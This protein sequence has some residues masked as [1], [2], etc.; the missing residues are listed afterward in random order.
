MFMMEDYPMNRPFYIG[1]NAHLFLWFSQV[2][3][4]HYPSHRDHF[5]LD[6]TFSYTFRTT[7]NAQTFFLQS[8][9]KYLFNKDLGPTGGIR[10]VLTAYTARRPNLWSPKC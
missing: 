9:L 3:G 4:Y 8:A 6:F 10:T 7:S 1:I 5:H 2:L